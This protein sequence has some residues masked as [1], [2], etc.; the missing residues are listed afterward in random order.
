[1]VT[2]RRGGGRGHLNR[3]R[4]GLCT[5]GGR[6]INTRPWRIQSLFR[7]RECW[8]ISSCCGHGD[9][10]TLQFRYLAA[11]QIWAAIQSPL[12]RLGGGH[13]GVGGG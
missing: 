5:S 9:R 10:D 3:R 12:E 11:S 6:R 2:A 1:M 13:N 4:R 8:A 7:L